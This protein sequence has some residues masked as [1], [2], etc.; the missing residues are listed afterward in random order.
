MTTQ[1]KA[2]RNLKVPFCF[3]FVS[4]PRVIS[5]NPR[6]HCHPHQVTLDKHH[7]PLDRMVFPDAPGYPAPQRAALPLHARW[8]SPPR[9]S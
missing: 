8:W 7:P 2:D 3:L 6:S 5:R 1:S 9:S 4:V